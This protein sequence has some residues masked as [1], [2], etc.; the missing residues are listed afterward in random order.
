MR[1]PIRRQISRPPPGQV[2]VQ[3]WMEEEL[4]D[5]GRAVAEARGTRLGPWIRELIAQEIKKAG[6]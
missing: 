2:S 1:D 3:V 5:Q 4:R 6:A